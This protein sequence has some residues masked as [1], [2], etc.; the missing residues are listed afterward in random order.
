VKFSDLSPADQK[1]VRAAFFGVARDARNRKRPSRAEV[2][3]QTPYRC[4]VHGET[5]ST[6]AAAERHAR[7]EGHGGTRLEAELRGRV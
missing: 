7:L 4:P 6:F 5:F 3:G 1:A 2:R